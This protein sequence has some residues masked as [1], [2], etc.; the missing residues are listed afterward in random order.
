MLSVGLCGCLFPCLL[1]LFTLH[2]YKHES[3]APSLIHGGLIQRQNRTHVSH[4]CR[5]PWWGIP[6]THLFAKASLS[7]RWQCQQHCGFTV[8]DDCVTCTQQET[9]V[10]LR[11]ECLQQFVRLWAELGLFPIFGILLACCCHLLPR[12]T[13]DSRMLQQNSF[14]KSRVLALSH[15]KPKLS[16]GSFEEPRSSTSCDSWSPQ[17]TLASLC[18]S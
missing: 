13:N 8:C 11:L 1:L 5:I 15:G 14:S 2:C 4:F 17:R 7:A 18:S 10:I 16:P 9:C 3:N 12:W 6:S